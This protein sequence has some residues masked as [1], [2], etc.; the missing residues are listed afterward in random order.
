MLCTLA[1]VPLALHYLGTEAYGFWVTLASIVLVLNTVDF[2]LGVGIQHA[3]ASAFGRD[4]LASVRTTFWTGAAILAVLGLLTL[5]AGLAAI[6][7]GSWADLLKVRDPELRRHTNA[8]LTIAL[9]SFALA[10]PFNAVNRLAAALQRG[11]LNAGWIALGSGLSLALVAAAARGNWGFLGFLAA[12]LLVPTLQGLGLLLH[13]CVSLGWR[14]VP[15]DLAG[16]AELRVLL[17]TS[18]YYSFPQLG[19]AL[20]QSVPALAISMAAGAAA[21][22]GYNLLFRI[23]GPVQQVQ[24]I[25]LTPIWPAYTEAHIR[26]DH[27]WITRTF[28]RTGAMFLGLGVVLALIAWKAQAILHLWV[29]TAD[30]VG[31]RLAA[32][33][34][35]WCLL[36]M[37]AQPS[38]YYLVGIGRLRA[39][40]WSATPGLAAAVVALFLGARFGSAAR[41]LECGAAALAVVL[42]PPLLAATFS[43]L[44]SPP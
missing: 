16:G 15:S 19:T 37:A 36:Q 4:D 11:W 17:R 29:G 14:P 3:M 2:G 33:V 24:M 43:A 10:L 8:A 13:L 23:F 6:H 32:V 40:A 41:V 12:S 30:A 38:I 7:L 39:L 44:K 18:F 25:L 42:L 9:G 1:Q 21:V 35:A 20:V 34:A 28:W 31:P 27:A 26:R 22:T 5:G